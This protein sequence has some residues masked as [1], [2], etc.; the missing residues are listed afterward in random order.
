MAVS[1]SVNRMGQPERPGLQAVAIEID[2]SADH[3]L[4]VTHF[5]SPNDPLALA[6]FARGRRLILHGCA[7]C[8]EIRT[9]R[10]G[11]KV[12]ASGQIRKGLSAT[13]SASR[14]SLGGSRS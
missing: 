9:W 1:G 5:A 14:R 10:L 11:T 4:V 8:F 2:A 7:V 6:K 13:S 12:G 3:R